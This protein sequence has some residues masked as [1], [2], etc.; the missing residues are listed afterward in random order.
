M[1]LIFTFV[2]FIFI[3]YY[4]F[5][6]AKTNTITFDLKIGQRCY[7]CKDDID[8]SDMEKLNLLVSNKSN[9]RL[10]DS[11]QRDEKI[12]S[13]F[14]NRF[15]YLN[16]VKLYLIKS[17]KIIVYS[18]ILIVILLFIDTILR[19]YGIKWFSYI[20]NSFI[21]IYWIFTIYRHKII[22]IKKPLS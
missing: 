5:L 11:C 22:S 20:Y 13:V 16:R 14:N 6:F 9:F 12:N 3:L 10:C 21:I 18:I 17:N 8:I 2:P 1:S 7:S 15:P 4:T 19:V